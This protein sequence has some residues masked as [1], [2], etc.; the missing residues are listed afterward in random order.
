MK[1]LSETRIEL[2]LPI[3]FRIIFGIIVVIL[4]SSMIAVGSGGVLPIIITVVAAIAGLYEERWVFDAGSGI[5]EHSY[6]VYPIVRKK[7]IDTDN[8]ETLVISNYKEIPEAD[9]DG[10]GSGKRWTMQRTLASFQLVRSDAK[11]MTI[12]IRNN[13]SSREMKD[14]ADSIASL[15]G[16]PLEMRD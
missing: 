5:V 4:V 8:V 15:I 2:V 9:D 10:R 12:E 1:R 11:A 6:G 3:G 13:K 14:N 7:T 16:K